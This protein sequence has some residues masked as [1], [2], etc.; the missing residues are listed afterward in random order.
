VTTTVP[1]T[2]AAPVVLTLFFTTSSPSVD[3]TGACEQLTGTDRWHDGSSAIPAFGDTIYLNNSTGGG[4]LG[5]GFWNTDQGIYYRTD[6]GGIV[7]ETG[8]CG[9]GGFN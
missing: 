7:I 8:P 9:D 1:P 4:T 5:A 2:T 3:S 6:A